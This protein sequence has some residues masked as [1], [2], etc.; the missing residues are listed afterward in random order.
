MNETATIRLLDAH[1]AALALFARQWCDTPDD[2][3]QEAFCRLVKQRTWPPEPAAWLFQVVKRIAIDQGIRDRRRQKRETVV[4]MERSWFH[5]SP[6]ED[7]DAAQA[8]EALQSLLDDE[9]EVIVLRLWSDLTLSQIALA[10]GCSV[11]SVHRKYETGIETLRLR[12]RV[13]CPK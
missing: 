9:R 3:V 4:A 10:L 13:T 1:G 7:L 12:L 11:S 6:I 5:E 8:T 2:A